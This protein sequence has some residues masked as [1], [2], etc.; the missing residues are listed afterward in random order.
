MKL[1]ILLA[2]VLFAFGTTTFAADFGADRHVKAG[3]KCAACHGEKNEIS[4]P[5]IEQC[6]KCHVPAQVAEKTKG[7]KP[8]NPHVSPHYGNELDC[9][10]CHTQHSEPANYCDQCHKFGFK[11]K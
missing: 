7:I 6:T 11:V 9:V 1:G 10:L 5:S 3:V 8:Q 2:G 4:D